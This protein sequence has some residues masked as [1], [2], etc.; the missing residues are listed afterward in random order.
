MAEEKVAF[1]TGKKQQEITPEEK[2]FRLIA[3]AGK[4]DAELQELLTRFA[5]LKRRK[6]GAPRNRASG[7]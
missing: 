2:L 7:I 4:D 1:Q 3:A 6:S 5:P